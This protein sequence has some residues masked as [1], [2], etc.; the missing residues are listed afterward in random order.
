MGHGA[1]GWIL[2]LDIIN[3]K[4]I[5]VILINGHFVLE[6]ATGVGWLVLFSQ[7]RQPIS[8]ALWA[9]VLSIVLWEGP[10]CPSTSS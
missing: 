7:L 5:R 1:Q 2:V 8:R 9:W 10:S 3:A 6:E 4:Y